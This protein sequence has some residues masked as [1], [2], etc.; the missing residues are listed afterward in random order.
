MKWTKEGKICT[1]CKILKTREEYYKNTRDGYFSKCKKCTIVN[2]ENR[3]LKK[4]YG[5]NLKD[6][7]LI[8]KEQNYRCKI[9]G[10]TENRGWGKFH[11]DHNH[12]TGQ[13]RGLLCSN[14]NTLLGLCY[15]NGLI[16]L[17]AIKYLE[18][19]KNDI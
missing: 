11:I 3:R 7:A 13:I 6:Y 1:Q 14:C 16:L 8:L 5:I 2:R 15:E 9:C 4:T 17:K 10:S 12:N 18:E 19:N